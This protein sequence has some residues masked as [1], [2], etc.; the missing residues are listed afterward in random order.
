MMKKKLWLGIG[1]TATLV[2]LWACG[3][4]ASD[5]AD[6]ETAAEKKEPQVVKIAAHL[7][8]MVDIIKV[9]QK[10]ME[11]EGYDLQLVQVND[12]QQYNELLQNKEVDANFA[13]H[14][15]FM[16]KFNE[17]KKADLVAI[18]KIYNAK[19]GFY[20]KNVTDKKDI[21]EGSKVAIP[22]DES[23]E[24]RALA[25]LDSEG[26]IKLK[27]GVGF[28][29]T[30]KDV[31]ENPKNLEWL[32]VD[33]LNLS[34]TYDEKDVSLVYNY[35]AY[36][37]KIGLT[38]KDALFLE[39]NIDERFAIVLAAREDNQD[40]AE[41]K[42]LKKAMTSDAVREFLEKEHGDTISVAF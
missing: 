4:K 15:P 21:P 14:E 30:V 23:N 8:T 41:I 10:E 25:I 29:G 7:P 17:E 22:S 20:S 31:E 40:T 26:I 6:T 28:N 24:G 39:T 9:A 35:P 3:N 18:Q 32:T 19:V 11:K 1:L 42:A 27:E 38:P 16:N 36:I 33:L 2:G 34:E 5:T 37:A 12:N 13:Q